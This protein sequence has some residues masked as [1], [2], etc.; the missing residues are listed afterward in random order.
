MNIENIANIIIEYNN[1][2]NENQNDFIKYIQTIEFYE[3]KRE[4]E[5]NEQ[6]ERE[7]KD[8]CRSEYQNLVDKLKDAG[9]T[10][11]TESDKEEL[12]SDGEKSNRE[13]CLNHYLSRLTEQGFD[14]DGYFKDGHGNRLLHYNSEHNQLTI[15]HEN[16]FSP[17]SKEFK[18]KESKVFSMVREYILKN[19][20]FYVK[21][22]CLICSLVKSLADELNDEIGTLVRDNDIGYFSL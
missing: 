17:I 4:K 22:S 21:D 12:L 14:E 5:F 2:S 11:N 3:K 16:L 18:I 9:K 13:D 10:R 1:L 15:S 7:L 6:K 8:L 19:T 20:N